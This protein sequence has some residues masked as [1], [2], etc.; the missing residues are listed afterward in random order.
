MKTNHS[1]FPVK[2]LSILKMFEESENGQ[3]RINMSNHLQFL[4]LP[5]DNMTRAVLSSPQMFQVLHLKGQH[6]LR[7][8]YYSDDMRR[9]YETSLEIYDH[10]GNPIQV[11]KHPEW[12][13]ELSLAIESEL[14]ERV[15]DINP[16]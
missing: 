4:K 15:L 8:A 13:M 10:A 14:L 6:R 1:L 2:L 9:V 16:L 5:N 12:S 7:L 3:S 11:I